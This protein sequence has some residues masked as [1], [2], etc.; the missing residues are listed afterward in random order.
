MHGAMKPVSNDRRSFLTPRRHFHA[1]KQQPFW[2]VAG[3]G[4]AALFV[5]SRYVL[6]AQ[7][8]VRRQRE[9]L[10]V[11]DVDEADASGSYPSST[12]LHRMERILGVDYGTSN[13]RLA[14]ASL[15]LTDDAVKVIESADGHRAIPAAVAVDNDTVSVGGLAKALMGR[16]PGYTAT[17]TRLLLNHTPGNDADLKRLTE[18]LP[19]QV[20]QTSDALELTLDGKSY[21]PEWAAEV[22]LEHLH[23]MAVR[24]FGEAE[25]YEGFPVVVAVPASTHSQ[26][27][28]KLERV[29]VSAGF[30]VVASVPEPIA[31]LFSVEAQISGKDGI[32]PTDAVFRPAASG[33]IAVFDMGG[34]ETTVSM[35]QKRKGAYKLL[36]T[37]SST[38][39][40]GK[41]VDDLLFQDVVA[42]FRHQHNIDLS[43]DH[44]A[45]FR[46]YEAVEVAKRELSSRK[47]TDLNLPFITADQ[48]GAK[49]LV[50]KLST[51]DLNRVCEEPMAQARA[52]CKS[53]LESAGL[54]EKEIDGL[55]VVGGGVRTTFVR[56]EVER[57]F[58]R[59]A[60]D[61]RDFR[62]EEAVVTGAAE[63]GRRLTNEQ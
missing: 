56:H 6:R 29:A 39:V 35:I 11:D 7:E 15:R 58:G 17:A 25:D 27:E 21:S 59:Q 8:R 50:Q 41:H 23:S 54:T 18:L 44:M 36:S 24:S 28:G 33:T 45:A 46:V 32:A 3:L 43:V 14:S 31:A 42:K 26:N 60:F 1:T 48:T 4:C 13:L 12:P 53:A 34:Y 19:Y 63:F 61:G 38:A 55:L 20:D 57:F 16:K 51:F 52:L 10:P 40:S 49:H 62:P 9:G 5:G 47:S 22:Q 37:I 2:L 30:N